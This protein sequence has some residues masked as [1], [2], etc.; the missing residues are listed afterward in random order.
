VGNLKRKASDVA[1]DA[2]A[3]AVNFF[4]QIKPKENV[5]VL[6][7]D[8][9]D[10]V[11]S[12]TILNI[13][14]RE[15]CQCSPIQF[16]TEWSMSLNGKTLEKIFSCKPKYVVISDVPGIDIDLLAKLS[17]KTK[18]LI[19]D[20]HVTHNYENVVYSN[21]RLLDAGA[22]IPATYL[23]YKI[24]K[25]LGVKN[26][27][28]NWIAAV[29]VL[30][31]HGVENCEDLFLELKKEFPELVGSTELKS[32]KLFENAKI[33]LLTKIIDSGRV[34]KADVGSNHVA[35]TLL[36]VDDYMDILEGRTASAKKLLG[37]YK[38]V[39]KEF[40]KL[41]EELKKKSVFIGNMI[42]FEFKSKLKLKSSLASAAANN[43]PDKI[44]VITQ[45][46]GESCWISMRRGRNVKID[47]NKLIQSAIKNIPGSSGGGHPE[48]VGG[49]IPAKYKDVFIKNLA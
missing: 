25:V 13:V 49:S 34:V 26:K 21:P 8:D 37:W 43:Y 11:C 17:E 16:S 29:G 36:E 47:L 33:G 3:P 41:M 18:V 24:S 38:I 28:I 15:F 32:D 27:K 4:R 5:V 10:G 35:K 31:D 42:I 12:G 14:L 7:D 19:V 40:D 20:H 23:A 39:E 46:D 2:I 22:Y 44:L 1:L 48:A 45:D 30:G 6:N 9:C